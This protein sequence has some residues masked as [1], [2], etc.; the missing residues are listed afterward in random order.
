MVLARATSP[1]SVRGRARFAEHDA[2]LIQPC[3]DRGICRHRCHGAQRDRVAAAVERRQRDCGLECARCDVGT[4]PLQHLPERFQ[5]LQPIIEAQH[6]Q[7]EQLCGLLAAHVRR[8]AGLRVHRHPCA[9]VEMEDILDTAPCIGRIRLRRREQR[10]FDRLLARRVP[11][12]GEARVA[13]AARRRRGRMAKRDDGN[14]GDRRERSA[15]DREPPPA[16][17][18]AMKLP[19]DL[20]HVGMALGGYL[21][22]STPDQR[23]QPTG[24]AL[25]G[26]RALRALPLDGLEQRDHERVLI[27]ARVEGTR[28]LLLGSHVRGRAGDGRQPIGGVVGREPEID[29]AHPAI[30]ADDEVLGLDVAMHEPRGV[31]HAR[32]VV[33]RTSSIARNTPP[34]QMPTS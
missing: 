17:E 21:A 15:R 31:A 5:I 19:R 4:A 33:P 1:A 6:A 22:Q 11:H 25:E 34:D 32:T 2:R 12:A 26:E 30:L 8:L 29:D 13:V 9:R 23:A 24:R 7:I 3:A 18:T 14:S 16:P 10:R 28:H 20:G 27:G